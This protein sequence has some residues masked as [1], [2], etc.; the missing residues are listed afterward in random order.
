MK[1]SS[2][3]YHPIFI[4]GA[5]RSGTTLLYNLLAMHEDVCWFSNLTEKRPS[6]PWLAT[7]HRLVDLPVLGQWMKRQFW[8]RTRPSLRP[9][10]ANRIYHAYV[11]LDNGR[12]L[13]ENDLTPQITHRFHHIIQ[14]HLYY[15]GKTRFLAKQ[16]T[17]NQHIRLINAL[18]P[19]ARFVHIIRDGRAVAASL[20]RVRW[21]PHI[22]VWWLGQTPTD[23]ATAG[24]DPIE[25]CIRHWQRDVAVILE[26]RHL[27]A[28]RYLEIRYEELVESPGTTIGQILAFVGLAD[29]AEFRRLLPARLT[30]MNH[31]WS[32]QLS[33]AQQRTIMQVAANMLAQLG[34]GVEEVA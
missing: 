24:N 23:W 25:L 7:T 16:T 14:T 31:K 20:A 28:D 8:Q 10:E 3:I 13:S 4:V 19:D 12:F 21:W 15:T 32:H 5:G 26:N 30:N 17:N 33:A 11:G 22:R 27:F 1:K 29:T 9:S 6:W 18:F 2:T 34:Y